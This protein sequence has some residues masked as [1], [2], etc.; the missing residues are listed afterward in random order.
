[1]SKIIACS[2]CGQKNRIDER[3]DN[4]QAICA[5]CWTK[6]NLPPKTVQA[7][8]PPKEPYSPPPSPKNPKSKGNGSTYGWLACYLVIGGVVWWV[9]AQDLG[10]SSKSNVIVKNHAESRPSPSYPEVALPY[11]GS[12]KI[13]SNGE[14]VAPLK[15]QTAQG[16][17]YLVK[18]VSLYSQQPVMTVFVQG[19]NTVSTEVPLGTY[20]IKYASGVKWYGY[21][22]LFGPDT[23]YSKAESLFTF[24]DTGNQISGYTITLYRVSNGNLRTSTINPEQF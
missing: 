12:S 3:T 4:S 5:K 7:P 14:R 23:G 9:I 22:H 13:Y 6:L 18:L 1:M 17:N 2:N 15:I 8:P 16:A 10:N 21:E 19:G 20:E 11:S 24:K